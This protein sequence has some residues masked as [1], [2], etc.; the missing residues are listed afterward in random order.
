M[1]KILKFKEH[2]NWYNLAENLIE[3]IINP[4]ILESTENEEEISSILK[5][6]QKD[7]NFNI[8]LIFTFGTGIASMYPIVLGLIKNQNLKVD[9]TTENI[10]LLTLTSVVI[11]ALETQ[12]DM[13]L[14]KEDV[15]TLL[16]ELKLRGIGNGIVKKMVNCLKSL[17]NVVGLLFKN[18]PNVIRSLVDM[19]AYTSLL[20]PTMNALSTIVNQYDWT[21]DTIIGNL[22]S[23]G[24]GILTFL[25]KNGFDYLVNKLKK[26]VKLNPELDKM[27][28]T[29]NVEVGDVEDYDVGNSKLI[30]EQ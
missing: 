21:M 26:K 5:N 1:T 9:L 19:F 3:G 13:D 11:L 7:L 30:R 4:P 27:S 25:A 23:L 20:I 2:E 17:G 16:T 29:G 12:K 18:T 15:K 6:L 22:S 24:I 28:K 10:V 14:S 8:K